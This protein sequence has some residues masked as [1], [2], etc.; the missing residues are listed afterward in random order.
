MPLY[1]LV[2][3]TDGSFWD[4]GAPRAWMRRAIRKD[5]GE[6]PTPST[7]PRRA[8]FRFDSP[9]TFRTPMSLWMSYGTQGGLFGNV[10]VKPFREEWEKVKERELGKNPSRSEFHVRTAVYREWIKRNRYKSVDLLRM[11]KDDGL[12]ARVV[13]DA[14][15]ITAGRPL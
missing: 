12:E 9:R 8:G 4:G 5:K 15:P 7:E 1:Y 3:T 2:D 6:N 14:E 10:V 13:G 11:L